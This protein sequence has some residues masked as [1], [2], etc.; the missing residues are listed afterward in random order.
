MVRLTD[1]LAMWLT[2]NGSGESDLTEKQ[3][4]EFDK[5]YEIVEWAE[6]VEFLPYD[7]IS[8]RT[9]FKE[10]ATGDF[11]A[12][13]GEFCDFEYTSDNEEHS[14]ELY[15]VYPRQITAFCKEDKK[16]ELPYNSSKHFY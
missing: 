1:E 16:D 4:A 8:V 6:V 3:D 10:K 2:Y 11:Y 9:V 14:F 12:L 7:L 5:L 13:E 15:R